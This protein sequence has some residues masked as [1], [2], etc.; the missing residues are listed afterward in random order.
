M[1]IDA[2]VSPKNKKVDIIKIKKNEKIFDIGIK[3]LEIILKKLNN[4]KTIIWSGPLGLF[5][6]KPYDKSTNS[7]VKLINDRG[8]KIISIAGG[9][10]T[11]AAIKKNKNFK[12]FTFLSTGGGAFL[13]WLEEY[14]L[15]GLKS[16]KKNKIN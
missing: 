11:L 6:K 2:V 7:L 13:K 16:L 9:G 1:P 8:K 12:N 3:T 4:S 14:N 15:P 10:D 5:E